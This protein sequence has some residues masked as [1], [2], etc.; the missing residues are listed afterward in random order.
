MITSKYRKQKISFFG[1]QPCF[2]FWLLYSKK[3]HG[4]GRPYALW[5]SWILSY[6]KESQ[7]CCFFFFNHALLKSTGASS[8]IPVGTEN[9]QANTELFQNP[10]LAVY[11]LNKMHNFSDVFLLHPSLH[12]HTLS[13]GRERRIKH[14]MQFPSIIQP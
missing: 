6:Y 7:K 14:I 9:V 2:D 4:L 8:P 11:V 12:T 3:S 13:W 1:T 5:M 10:P